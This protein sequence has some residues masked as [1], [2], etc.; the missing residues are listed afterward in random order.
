MSFKNYKVS[1]DN[2]HNYRYWDAVSF[3]S[4][5]E[6]YAEDVIFGQDCLHLIAEGE[7]SIQVSLGEENRNYMVSIEQTLNFNAELVEE[8]ESPTQRD[9]EFVSFDDGDK[10]DE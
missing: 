10:K 5:A 8:E 1:Y 7:V 3:E 4:A 6:L 2:E 9:Q